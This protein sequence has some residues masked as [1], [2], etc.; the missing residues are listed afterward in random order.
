MTTSLPETASFREFA[1]LVPCKPSWVT[2]LRQADRLVLTDDGKRVRVQQSLQRIEDTKDQ[3]RAGVAQRHAA[4]RAANNASIP[5]TPIDTPAESVLGV[6]GE[7]ET[8]AP[9]KD[10]S[11]FQHWRERGERAKALAAERENAIAE[12]KLMDASAV[13]D[14]I[15]SHIASLRAGL[16]SLPD[17]LAPQIVG[18]REEPKVRALIADAI[19]QRLAELSRQFGAI[20]KDPT[21]RG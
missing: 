9:A 11:M 10:T 5:S 3:S 21:A 18:V 16:E 20:A 12:G 1:D 6:E 8:P 17:F 14:A 4:A 15:K 2:A 19:E 7:A 13:V